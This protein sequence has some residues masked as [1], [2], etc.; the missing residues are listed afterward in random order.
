MQKGEKECLSDTVAKAIVHST[1]LPVATEH[2]IFSLKGS[3]SLYSLEPIG[4]IH[5]CFSE[6]FG[7]PR[8]PGLV[9]A[10]T[11]EL[12]LCEGYGR[13]EMVKGLE[14]FSH[15]WLIFIFHDTI[16][17]GWKPTVR[18]PRLGGQQ[19][20]GVYATRSPHRPNHLGMSSVKLE[21]IRMDEGRVTLELSGVDLLNGT[22]VLDIKPYVVYSDAISEASLGFIGENDCQRVELTAE[23]ETFC[24]SYEAKTGRGLYRLITQTLA[25]DPRPASQRTVG[26][27]YGVLLW[28]VN[29]R[30]RVEE[31]GFLVLSCEQ[32]RG[33]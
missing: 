3:T 1:L 22:P 7:I 2:T 25:A 24:E 5:S 29:V 12:V 30:W 19:R 26:R 9:P 32:V 15:L 21:K 10:A 16:N 31:W 6:K 13:A 33:E 20:L 4:V 28:D 8:Q 23:V 18:P 14:Q 27:E 17:E 11:A